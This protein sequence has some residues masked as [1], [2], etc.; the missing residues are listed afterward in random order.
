MRLPDDLVRIDPQPTA[1]HYEVESVYCVVDP[2]TNIAR[3]ITTEA[4]TPIP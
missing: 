2:E 4:W 1:W 3:R